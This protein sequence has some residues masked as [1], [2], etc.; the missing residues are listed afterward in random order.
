MCESATPCPAGEWYPD[1]VTYHASWPRAAWPPPFAL[2]VER[3]NRIVAAGIL[4]PD[5][6]AELI[7]GL[8]VTK[9]PKS[10]AHAVVSCLLN[11]RLVRGLGD[12]WFLSI[13]P[14]IAMPE[15]ASE[16]EPDFALLRYH[17]RHYA[18]RYPDCGDVGLIIEIVDPASRAYEREVRCGLYA[19]GGIPCVWLL[20]PERHILIVLTDPTPDGYATVR[21]FGE[22]AEVPIVLDGVE[23]ARLAVREVLP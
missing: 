22:E 12:G 9:F 21:E 11:K 19:T 3:Y 23:V 17:P 15:Q 7:H 18:D 5:D 4:G 6:Q 16:P 20:D 10:P 8:L 14:P 1:E 13:A 2:S